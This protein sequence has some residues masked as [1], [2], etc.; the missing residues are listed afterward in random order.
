M[1]GYFTI[2]P[3]RLVPRSL[4]TSPYWLSTLKGKHCFNCSF[5]IAPADFTIIL[6][7]CKRSSPQRKL[8]HLWDTFVNVHPLKSN[9]KAA[10][11]QQ[12]GGGLGGGGGSGVHP[13]QK[14]R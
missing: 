5:V 6:F 10:Q 7:L 11:K 14:L 9:E 12:G 8:F 13:D 3:K 2:L 1:V 4:T